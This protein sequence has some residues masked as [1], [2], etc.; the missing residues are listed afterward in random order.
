MLKI[1]DKSILSYKGVSEK[2]GSIFELSHQGNIGPNWLVMQIKV[3]SHKRYLFVYCSVPLTLWNEVG[4]LK[5]N[6]NSF[7][8]INN[9]VSCQT[10]RYTKTATET[11][12]QF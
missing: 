10:F 2:G 6:I 4:L 3:A 9:S 5:G 8:N 7:F 1:V 11:D 12:R